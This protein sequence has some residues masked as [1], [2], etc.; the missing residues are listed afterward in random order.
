MDSDD[1]TF[2]QSCTEFSD[3]FV[4]R[5]EV[6]GMDSAAGPD[7]VS[8]GVLVPDLHVEF[9]AVR[10]GQVAESAFLNGGF[11][12]WPREQADRRANLLIASQRQQLSRLTAAAVLAAAATV[13][14][15]SGGPAFAWKEF[16]L[17]A[18]QEFR[19]TPSMTRP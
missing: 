8:G 5:T 7:P 9:F 6:Y 18:D 1:R 16:L 13:L 10:I 2:L 11:G 19:K 14:R 4:C 17:S 3:A 12:G 15:V